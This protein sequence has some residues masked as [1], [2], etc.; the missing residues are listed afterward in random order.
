MA[1]YSKASLAEFDI[2]SLNIHE[3][4]AES[5][6]LARQWAQTLCKNCGSYH[7]SWQVLRLLGVLNSM[8]SDD[9]FLVRQ[10]DQAIA[11][12]AQRILVSGAADYALQARIAAVAKKHN[13]KPQITVVDRCETPLKLNL[14]YA[15][16]TGMDVELVHGDILDYQKPN[17]FD[18]VCTHSFLC[19]FNE[20]DRQKLVNVWWGCLAPAGA[21]L[22]AQRARPNDTSPMH[23][24]SESQAIS[25]GQR[26]Y[27]LADQQFNE[28][29]IDPDQA[30]SLAV[31]YAA[32]RSTYLVR[33][34]EQL[35]QLFLQ[36]GFELEHF[37]SAGHEQ[38]EKDIPSTP[39]KPG[40][41][42]LRILARK[43]GAGRAA[44]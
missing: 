44:I 37:A 39:T 43:P 2:R 13:K 23:G 1:K 6:L 20:D 26:A 10:L 16:E 17:Y 9:D 19:N 24:F 8:R 33:D 7:G 27:Q 14:W 12:G 35:S 4:L 5:A 34:S 3:P 32:N 42:R 41:R 18:L 36:Q 38:L 28:F 22:T 40:H 21:V 29:G 30:R 11:S 15:N 25:L 31:A